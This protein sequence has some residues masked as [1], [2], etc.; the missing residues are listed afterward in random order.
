M[1]HSSSVPSVTRDVSRALTKAS[2]SNFSYAFLFLPKRKREALYAVYAF[3][4]V[5]D[6]LVDEAVVPSPSADRVPRPA[7]PP[8]GGVHLPAGTPIERLKAWRA[9]L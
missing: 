4:R 9:E 3:C 2:R 1:T 7:S 6:D 8:P 5:T